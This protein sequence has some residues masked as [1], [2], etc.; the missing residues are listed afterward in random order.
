MP[1]P[2]GNVGVAR[3][4]TL[5]CQI[6]FHPCCHLL[7]SFWRLIGLLVQLNVHACSMLYQHVTIMYAK[8]LTQPAA[9]YLNT[10]ESYIS[11]MSEDY[12]YARMPRPDS[13]YSFHTSITASDELQFVQN[14]SASSFFISSIP[15][16]FRCPYNTISPNSPLAARSSSTFN[17]A[18]SQQL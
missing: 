4:L 1:L 7:V 13:P 11:N 9:V 17:C 6:V 5:R 8:S 3:N 10:S 2:L 14:L 18:S 15:L 12:I 16:T